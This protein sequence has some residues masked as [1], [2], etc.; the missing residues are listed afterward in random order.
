MRSIGIDYSLKAYVRML[1]SSSL[2][3]WA[4]A[5]SR[6]LVVLMKR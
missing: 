1:S 4:T 3:A 2:P 6:N 5:T